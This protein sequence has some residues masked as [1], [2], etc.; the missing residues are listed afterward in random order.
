MT[1]AFWKSKLTAAQKAS[2]AVG[3]FSYYALALTTFSFPI[4]GIMVVWYKVNLVPSI[5]IVLLPGFLRCFVFDFLWNRGNQFGMCI[6]FVGIIQQYAF[7]VA[8]NNSIL[9]TSLDWIPTVRDPSV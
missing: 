1:Q 7:L 5:N 8:L 6:L 4:P 9:G 2:Y 3:S